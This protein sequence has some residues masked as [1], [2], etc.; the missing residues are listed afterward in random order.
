MDYRTIIEKEGNR[1]EFSYRGY[2]ALIV[3]ICPETLGH[4]CGYVKIPKENK[5]YGMHYE[6]ISEMYD[7]EMPAHGGLTFSG[8]FE[9]GDWWIGFDCAHAGDIQ[10]AAMI[11]HEIDARYR[12]MEYVDGVLRDMIDFIAEDE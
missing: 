6:D 10:P 12:T 4:L 3:R 5:L 9:E 7:Y 11:G 2:Q 1:K 8:S